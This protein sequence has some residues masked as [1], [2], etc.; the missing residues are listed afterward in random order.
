MGMHNENHVK[1]SQSAKRHPSPEPYFQCCFLDWFLH[2]TTK[3]DPIAVNS[4]DIG[5]VRMTTEM[6]DSRSGW[7]SGFRLPV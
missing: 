4:L 3:A 6:R 1:W 7:G 2:V 5:Y